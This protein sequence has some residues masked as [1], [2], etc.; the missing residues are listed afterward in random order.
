MLTFLLYARLADHKNQKRRKLL[1]CNFELIFE[2]L[3]CRVSF[4]HNQGLVSTV[5]DD[6]QKQIAQQNSDTLLSLLAIV[7]NALTTAAVV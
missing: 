1:T 2:S 4:Q 6:F 3:W 5:V 7:A